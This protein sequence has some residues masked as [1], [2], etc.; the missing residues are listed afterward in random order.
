MATQLQEQPEVIEG[1]NEQAEARDFDTEARAL[2]W[3]PKD[4]FRGDPS[5]WTDAE[6]FVTRGE[7][8]MPLLK[9]ENQ[10]LKGKIEYLERTVKRLAKA[11]Q[12]AYTSALED[13]KARQKEAVEFGDVA[14]FEKIDKQ[15]D[16]M[17][18]DMADD[19]PSDD[20]NVAYAEFK[21]D[22]EWYGLGGQAGASDVE[23]RARNLADTLADKYAAQGLQKTMT[24]AEFFAKI[25]GEVKE[26]YPNLEGDTKAAPRPKPPSDVAGVTRPG[27][28]RT[29][30]T[31][32]NLP[33]EAKAQALRF[34]E[35]GIIKAKDKAEAL[36]KFAKDYDW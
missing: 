7:T 22:N 36:D 27:G 15:I 26:K 19:A 10:Q 23:R 30:K 9:K 29:A 12:T 24:P 1:A 16:G 32:V 6:S 17:R 13:L 11:E 3:V 21:S 33:P 2:G 31:G 35:K 28:A 4:E 20:P 18:R 25:A 5:R 34:F 8:V 14:A